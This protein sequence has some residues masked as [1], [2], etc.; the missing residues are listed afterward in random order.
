MLLYDVIRVLSYNRKDTMRVQKNRKF[1]D[2][3]MNQMPLWLQIVVLVSFITSIII[4]IV[5]GNMYKENRQTIINTEVNTSNKLLDLEIQSLERYIKDLTTFAIQP[6]YDSTFTQIIQSKGVLDI[7]ERNYIKNEMRGYFY[8]RND[9]GSYYIYLINHDFVFKR[10][11]GA[12]S[13]ASFSKEEMI[14]SEEYQLCS[15]GKYYQAILPT[16]SE[17]T[18]LNY[19]QS[20]IRIKNQIPVAIVNFEVD[21]T[22]VDT[23]VKNHQDNGEFLC[24]LNST[25]Q[26]LYSGND[27]LISKDSAE[28]ISELANRFEDDFFYL[29]MNDMEYLITSSTSETY[30][31]KLVSLKPLSIIDSDV[32]HAQ[33]V[34][35]L[36]GLLLWCLSV[37]LTVLSVRFAT[38]PLS[39]LA[40]K[41][42]GV[43]KGDF[44]STVKIYGSKE[45]VHLSHNFND[46]IYQIDELIKKNY[47]SEL[48]EKTSRLI[49]LEAQINPHFLYNTLQAISTE[50][51][52]NDQMKIHTMITSLAANLRYTIKGGDF[53]TLQEEMIYV[54]NYI[55]LQK[56]RLDNRLS[57]SVSIQPEA[58]SL[59]IPKISIQ[60]LVENSIIH[61]MVG[62]VTSIHITI[63]ANLRD[64]MLVIVVK[65]NGCGISKDYILELQK[66]F[67]NPLLKSTSSGIGL[68]NLNSRLH[69]LYNNQ[70]SLEV[71]SQIGNYTSITLYIPATDEVPYV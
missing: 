70:S 30:Q 41:L 8:S 1:K 44:T 29:T 50:A 45:I 10:T 12:G 59:F 25:N 16:D 34:S 49:A 24:V 31:L 18:F 61:G 19:Y 23:L 51:L 33:R 39:T 28:R 35:L 20:I 54:N 63:S 3:F 13:I 52:L 14:A 56:I 68:I 53:V 6:C 9:I 5:F 22:Y 37:I 38:T 62:D 11:I 26:L 58:E 71:D 17:D 42:K 67:F 36:W 21:N 4:M 60:T 40:N 7:S 43:G 32:L 15:K 47:L 66:G 64:N 46:M 2:S 27:N 55:L 48:N 57:V 69:I 65:D